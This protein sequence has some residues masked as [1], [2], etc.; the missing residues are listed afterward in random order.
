M[1]YPLIIGNWKLNGNSSMIY[2]FI[3]ELNQKMLNINRCKISIAPPTIYLDR[4][5]KMTSSKIKVCAQNVDINISG[6]FTGETS[7]EMLKET[8]VEYVIV[9]HSERRIY[10]KEDYDY[11]AKKY[12]II[13]LFNL[14]PVLCIGENAREN[15]T[16]KTEEICKLQIDTIL[17]NQ[18]IKAFRNAV[19]AYEPIWA[20]GTGQSATPLKIQTTHEFIRSY[21]AKKDKEIADQLIIQYGGS[22]NIENAIKIINQPDV[23]GLL[24]GT[25]SLN[26]TVFSRIIQLVENNNKIN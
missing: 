7:I 3:N 2:N 15:A 21:L 11:I 17:K 23:D 13:K 1:K 26:A 25:A 4:V 14:I 19:I 5:K 20:I 8:G 24:I 16:G 18:G 6:A 22:I 12:S 10:H 9:G